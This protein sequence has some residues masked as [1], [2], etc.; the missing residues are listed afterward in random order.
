MKI[1]DLQN[2]P[3]YSLFSYDCDMNNVALKIPVS[4]PLVDSCNGLLLASLSYHQM[5]QL[6]QPLLELTVNAQNEDSYPLAQM[7]HF[8]LSKE[9]FVVIEVIV[10]VWLAYIASVSDRVIARTLERKPKKKKWKG[11]GEGDGRRGNACQQPPRFWKTP[12]DI[13]RFGSFVN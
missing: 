10:R 4:I 9:G 11:K 6:K 3:C 2:C 8:Y 7:F 12:L 13:S 1:S 5:R